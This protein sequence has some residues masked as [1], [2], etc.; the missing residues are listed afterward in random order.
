M[1]LQDKFIDLVT[2]EK[3]EDFLSKDSLVCFSFTSEIDS[4]QTLAEYD[5]WKLQINPKNG[6]CRVVDSH[7]I[8]K[9]SS[10]VK[11]IEELIESYI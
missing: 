6:I 11:K 7:I 1:S 10:S 3:I 2:S 4:W 5:G 9:V 8:R